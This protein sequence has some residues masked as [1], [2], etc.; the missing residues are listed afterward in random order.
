KTQALERALPKLDQVVKARGLG[1]KSD[2]TAAASTTAKGLQ[3]LLTQADTAKKV[4][5]PLGKTD[6]AKK[7][8]A[9]GKGAAKKDTTKKDTLN[10]DSLKLQA[11]GAFSSLLQQGDTPGGFF[12][13]A[14]NVP[15]LEGYLADSAVKAAMPPGKDFLPG[16]DTNV[17]NN[18]TYK[19]YY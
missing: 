14:D 12:V 6:S 4:E 18:K 2:T 13:A 10:A 8:A 17:F 5:L 3:G 16:T 7:L 19:S 15:T 11:G 1:K 9:A